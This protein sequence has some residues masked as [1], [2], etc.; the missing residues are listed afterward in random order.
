MVA[1]VSRAMDEKELRESLR[2]HEAQ[3]FAWTAWNAQ[4]LLLAASIGFAL[5]SWW[6]FGA[7]LLLF[8]VLT[9]VR[10][11]RYVT[12]VGLSILWAGVGWEAG[13]G[14]DLAMSIVLAIVFFVVAIGINF[15]A[16]MAFDESDEA[17]ARRR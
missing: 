2:T 5:K 4:C 1:G 10:S 16:A 8:V 17:M 14:R 15:T 13:R 7:S 6:A 9:M 11:L 12:A 3:T